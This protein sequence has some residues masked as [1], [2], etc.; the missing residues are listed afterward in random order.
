MSRLS[1]PLDFRFLIFLTIPLVLFGALLFGSF[2]GEGN[3]MPIAF[4]VG[5]AAGL[6][7]L[8]GIGR[9]YWLLVPILVTAT[10]SSR[11]LPVPLSVAEVG[12]ISAFA[13]YIAH[14]SLKK[15]TL[16]YK[17]GLLDVFMFINL[18]YL[19]VVFFRNPTGLAFFGSESV[20][21]RHYITIAI[22][23]MSYLVLVHSRTTPRLIFWL[24]LLIVL[25]NFF[26][27]ILNVITQVYP[28][29][30]AL[31]YPFYSGV[32]YSGLVDVTRDVRSDEERFFALG[33]LGIMIVQTLC[34]YF[35]PALALTPGNFWIGI[36]LGLALL[37]ILFSGF[38]SGI[39][40]AGAYIYLSMFFRKQWGGIFAITTVG[41]LAMALIGV[42]NSVGVHLPLTWQRALSFIPLG[43]EDRAVELA[44]GSTDWR[45]D[46]WRDALT[47]DRIIKDKTFGDGFG[48][49]ADEL[50]IMVTGIMYGDSGAID[51]KEAFMVR[52]S[53][54][55]GPV[56]SIRFV[57]YVGLAL[58]FAFQIVFFREAIRL[59]KECQGTRFFPLAMFIG[60]WVVYKVF[61]F[62]VIF[63]AYNNYI[64]DS[65]FYMGLLHL[66]RNSMR[67]EQEQNGAPL[68]KTSVSTIPIPKLEAIR[69]RKPFPT[70]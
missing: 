17:A 27:S 62:Y 61:E 31:I 68:K 53:F 2:V 43:W 5:G 19:A 48:F 47:T 66:L 42:G 59:I 10:G 35:S 40:S 28:Q 37:G 45:V 54:H 6:G 67:A 65:L 25:P 8:L 21:G 12:V 39:A 36:L 49:R 50:K 33:T 32:D 64:V 4:V 7:L 55:S 38:R 69:P 26:L 52:G 30:G 34:A 46:M 56:S 1:T 16:G 63:G 41:V 18:G 51:P 24:P 14:L 57:G 29:L 44:K 20:G 70:N 23:F 58:L 22:A 13:L 60:L 11:L 15:A 9:N 3:Y